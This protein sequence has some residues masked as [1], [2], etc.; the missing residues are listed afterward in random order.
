LNGWGTANKLAYAGNNTFEGFALLESGDTEYKFA[1]ANW[2]VYNFGAP[3]AA[4]GITLGSNPGN[5]L[6]QVPPGEQGYY[7]VN[8]FSFPSGGGSRYA[9]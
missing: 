5:L 8:F 4:N 6:L 1:D 2:G 3:F 9:F 7:R